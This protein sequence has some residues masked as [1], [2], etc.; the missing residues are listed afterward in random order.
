MPLLIRVPWLNRE[1]RF[2]TGAI[3]QIVLATLLGV[4]LAAMWDWSLGAGLVFG[5][6]LSVDESPS[7]Q[8]GDDAAQ[9]TDG[10]QNTGDLLV[11]ADRYR[12]ADEE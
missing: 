5:L 1:Q 8:P 3:G 12:I 6:S 4:A 9:A 11:H 7:H 10:E 2:I